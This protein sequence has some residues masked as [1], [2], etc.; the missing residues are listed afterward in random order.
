MS[1]FRKPR[2]DTP[3][4]PQSALYRRTPITPFKAPKGRKGRKPRGQKLRP[5]TLSQFNKIH[6]EA[7]RNKERDRA[8]Q[9]R[10]DAIKERDEARKERR[11][12]LQIEDRRYAAKV[13]T[14]ARDRAAERNF[15]A[16][17]L[18]LLRQQAAAGGG[19]PPPA[20]NIAPPD[21]QVRPV[22]NLPP[23]G[24][25]GASQGGGDYRDTREEARRFAAFRQ[26]VQ[27]DIRRGFA[28]GARALGLGQEERRRP[29]V[30][31]LPDRR[32][33]EREREL[34]QA[35]AEAR[36]RIDPNDPEYQ[37]QLRADREAAV[38]Q[39]RGL[40]RQEAELAAA[41]RERDVLQQ[42]QARIQQER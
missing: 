6:T 2:P 23:A 5:R 12:R 4:L 39:G 1:D 24:Q 40:G 29:E 22:I 17:Q 16:E 10:I 33:E 27:A 7:A 34:E 41:Q 18:R 36:R 3:I 15:R 21:I 13:I 31:V 11:E 32:A 8:E 42:T 20:I 30:V 19:A 37:A 35:R 38:Q 14:D 26:E 25:L 28:E 9:E